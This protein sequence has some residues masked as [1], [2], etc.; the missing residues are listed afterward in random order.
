MRKIILLFSILLTTF[1][2]AQDD[3]P[4]QAI[5]CDAVS[6]QAPIYNIHVDE[7]NVKWVANQDGLFKVYDLSYSEPVNISSLDQSL[8]SSPEAMQISDGPKTN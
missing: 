7:D 2:S 5:R 8:I 1:L 3:E 4:M 6:R